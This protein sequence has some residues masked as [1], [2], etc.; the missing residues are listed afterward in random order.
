M[1]SYMNE[2]FLAVK[3]KH[4]SEEV[5]QA[6]RN[7]CGV[8]KNRKRR[9]R[10]TANLSKRYEAAA[11]RRTNQEKLRSA[12]L[13]SRS[14]SIQ[15]A[16]PSE[17][18]VP[19]E[20]KAAGFQ[21]CADELG[22][23]VKEHDTKKLQFHGGVAGVAKKLSTSI[24]NG[25]ADNHDS[26]KRR[27]EIYGI[28][29]FSEDEP[30]GF[31]VFVWNALQDITFM[32][33]G[34]FAFLSLIID[35][36]VHGWPDGADD[37][38][39]ALACILLV[40]FSRALSGYRQSSSSK[41]TKEIPILVT[42]SGYKWKL[43]VYDLVPGDIVHLSIGDQ[44]PADGLFISESSMLID[45]SSLT[46][47]SKVVVNSQNPFLLSGTCLCGTPVKDE[48]CGKV[49]VTAVG[50]RTRLGNKLIGCGAKEAPW[51]LKLIRIATIIGNKRL[52]FFSVTWAILVTI[53]FGHK[54]QSEVDVLEL[55]ELF[56]VAVVK[57]GI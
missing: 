24:E 23:I 49:M 19:E 21:I 34:L 13:V 35:I 27:Q 51:Q 52:F 9:F 36:A 8:I 18:T 30:Q 6:W 55:L 12:V 4:S 5:L 57:Q 25:L 7:L 31:R 53:L 48:S 1:E 46:G 37:G 2:A 50:M 16:Q 28:N 42:R 20:V 38:F 33:L 29:E 11:L 3:A 43:P 39:R 54:L 22:S 17:Y 44:V 45:E 40:V 10:F 56:A 26:I 15:C 32:I 47:K 14:Q 41:Q